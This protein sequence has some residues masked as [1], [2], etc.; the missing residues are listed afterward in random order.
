LIRTDLQI[1]LPE[2]CYGR[3]TARTNLA[4]YRH[5]CIGGG[6]IDQDFCGN[7]S[8][9]LYNHSENPYHIHRGDKIAKLICE[10]IYFPELDLV[11][12][13]DD[14]WHGARG[15]GLTGQN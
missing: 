14:T 1:K 6:V 7:L 3:I 5:I 4:L 13:L 11:E 8:M 9:L 10:K 12:K 2:G 15:F